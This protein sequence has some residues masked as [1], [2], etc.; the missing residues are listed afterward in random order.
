MA[1]AANGGGTEVRKADCAAVIVAAGDGRRM[2]RPKQ[3][4]PVGGVPMLERSIAEFSRLPEVGRIVVVTTAEII[5]RY[6]GDWAKKNIVAVLGGATR[7]ESVRAGVRKASGAGIVAVHDAARPLIRGEQ[8]SA[9][10]AEARK[11]GAS[12]LAVPVKDT[13]KTVAADGK[14][15]AGTLERK[16]LWAAQTPQCYRLEV[17]E[18]ALAAFPEEK[19][20]TDES[21]LVERNGGK[22]TLVEG[23]DSNI[24]V[25][26]PADLAAA[27]ALLGASSGEGK[28]RVGL[29]YDIHRMVPGRPLIMGGIRIPHT[30]GLL[31]HSDGDVVLHAACDA[32]LGAI[33]AG[34][35]GIY[36]PP[37]DLTIMGISSIAIV[38]KTLDVLSSRG[39]A[40][41]QLDITV[42][43]E[44]PKLS[45][46][47]PA[48]RKSVADLFR[49]P[50]ENVSIKAKSYEGLGEIGRGEAMA[51]N[52]L[53]VVRLK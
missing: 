26:T 12:V 6:G 45:G 50:I 39:A 17:L 24:K 31:G 40:V 23:S 15:V 10:I 44:E 27:D 43:A 8:I 7:L 49:L 2:G 9:A 38:E 21:Q 1:S 18:S 3:M 25:T 35:I 14:T 4:L 11:S 13:I 52:A 41:A 51:C 42:I 53:A 46:H 33:A 48:L 22:V 34:E 5:E 36:F 32:A 30:K 47:Y 20:A 16:K 28:M 37:T 19:D 29:G